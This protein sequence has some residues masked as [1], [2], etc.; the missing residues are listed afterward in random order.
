MASVVDAGRLTPADRAEGLDDDWGQF[1]A[2]WPGWPQRRQVMLAFARPLGS[3]L[4]APCGGYRMA[5]LDLPPLDPPFPFPFVLQ[6][7]GDCVDVAVGEVLPPSVSATM[8]R[9]PRAVFSS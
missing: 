9:Y 8:G 4:P 2:Q 1:A 3:D 6:D 5:A 7:V